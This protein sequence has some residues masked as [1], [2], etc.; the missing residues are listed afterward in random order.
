MI[1][2]VFDLFQVHREEILQYSPIVIQNVLSI[3]PKTFDAI[4]VIFSSLVHIGF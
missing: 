1:E 2:P 4:D 3:T